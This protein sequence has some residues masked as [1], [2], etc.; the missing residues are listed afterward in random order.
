MPEGVSVAVLIAS[1]GSLITTLCM[2]C[3][4]SRCRHIEVCGS[5]LK[6][7]REVINQEEEK[8]KT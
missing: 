4:K 8:K 6:L 5:C 3:R 7:D 1:L 2:S